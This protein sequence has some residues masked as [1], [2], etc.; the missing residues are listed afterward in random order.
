MK[1]T[2]VHVEGFRSLRDVT[3]E[4]GPVTVLIGPNG[5]G[6][7]NVLG[8]LGLVPT[9]WRR[10]LA[11]Y[12][13]R[14]GGA[15][16][17]LYR[18]QP[19]ASHLS[20]RVEW[21]G[22]ATYQARLEAD[23]SDGMFFAEESV[24]NAAA[25]RTVFAGS[26]PESRLAASVV[27]SHNPDSQRV[28]EAFGNMRVFH[29]H[30]TSGAAPLRTN[31]R[32]INHRRLEADGSNLASYLLWLRD[33]EEP[34]HRAAWTLFSGLVRRVA[35]FIKELV[36]T[37]VNADPDTF[38]LDDPE[39]RIDTVTIRLDWIDDQDTRFG[40]THLSDG[41]LRAIALYAALTQPALPAFIC[42]DEPELGLHPAALNILVGLIRSVSNRCQVVLATQSPAFLDH[43]SAEEVVVAERVD[44]A[45]QLRRLEADKLASWLED[46][47]L[48]E[49][50]EKNVLGGRP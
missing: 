48:S 46:Y 30:D 19:E 6:K 17:I 7:S 14:A 34:S 35:P 37:P 36:P 15:S 50:Y 24:T 49:L 5:A 25:K 33:S 45:T 27:N 44:G 1:I 29:F 42:I 23:A 4:P 26:Q 3:F 11:R 40:V 22:E 8:F 13:A 38:R 16:Q 18:G 2:R 20:F 43:F 32:A 12:V 47:S 21:D 9:L 28:V 31:S 10:S 41:T 39:G